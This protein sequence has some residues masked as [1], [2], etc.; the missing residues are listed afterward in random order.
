MTAAF[1]ELRSAQMSVQKS[2]ALT[3]TSR[4]THYRRANPK[5]PMHGPWLARRQ[6]P[7]ALTDTE[8]AEVTDLLTSP[9][10]A[11]LAIPQV[12]ARELDEGRYWCSISTMY[13]VARA[14][15]QVSERRRLATHPPRVRPELVAHAPSE[16]WSWDIERHEA[17]ST[18]W[19]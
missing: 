13:R 12:W 17:P 2:C 4:A 9:A 19:R 5:G 1:T 10:Y 16:V 18:E 15:G 3:G 8:R 11:D 7:S 6:P 14:A